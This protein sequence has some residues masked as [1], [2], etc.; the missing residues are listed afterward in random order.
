MS[1]GTM[2]DLCCK[3]ILMGTHSNLGPIDPYLG[4]VPA[5][6]V[7]EEFDRAYREI[8]AGPDK[9]IVWAPILAKYQ[10][11]L[12]SQC[13]NAVNWSSDFVG[14]ELV[15]CMLKSRK[16]KAKIADKIVDA[17]GDYAGNKRHER[18]IHLDERKK[19]GIKVMPIEKNQKLQ[20]LIPT[21]HHWF[22]HTLSNTS[23]YK[24]I[25]NQD[26]VSY[27]RHDR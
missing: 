5:L 20:D 6:G 25:E 18:H 19:L 17:L 12:I 21:T 13:E 16:D 11:T 27:V 14:R 15:K 2:I 1:A 3:E 10:P 9:A 22:I 24:I 7:L 8:K 4:N 26:G 23:T